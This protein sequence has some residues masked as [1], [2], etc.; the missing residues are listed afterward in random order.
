MERVK[1][2]YPDVKE[3]ELLDILNSDEVNKYTLSEYGYNIINDSYIKQ[4]D[5]YN[6]IFSF[7]KI[8]GIIIMR[9]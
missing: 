7:F 8:N 9:C 3:E 5:N 4:N 6:L 2:K 1:E